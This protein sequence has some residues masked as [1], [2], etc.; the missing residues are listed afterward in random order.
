MGDKLRWCLLVGFLFNDCYFHQREMISFIKFFP[1][2]RYFLLQRR[3][4]EVLCVCCLIKLA[5]NFNTFDRILVDLCWGVS[6]QTY[7][8][9]VFLGVFLLFVA[10]LIIICQNVSI[11]R[12]IQRRNL[13]LDS[14]LSPYMSSLLWVDDS[15]LGEA[16]LFFVSF[17]ICYFHQIVMISVIKLCRVVGLADLHGVNVQRLFLVFKSL[18]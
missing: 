6:S 18:V 17:V 15:R 12:A 9:S 10:A 14:R 7:M 16:L 5:L 1:V 11:L 8:S 3:L 4:G 2:I 13:E